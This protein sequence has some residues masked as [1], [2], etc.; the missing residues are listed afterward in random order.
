MNNE[1]TECFDSV[2][3]ATHSQMSVPRSNI[4]VIPVE[5][6]KQMKTR[7]LL[8]VTALMAA[9][10]AIAV[11]TPA[12]AGWT[13]DVDAAS[14][15]SRMK[16]EQLLQVRADG[17]FAITLEAINSTP[18]MSGLTDAPAAKA[19]YAVIVDG[20]VDRIVTWDGYSPNNYGKNFDK[21]VEAIS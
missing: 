15:V 11:P 3:P 20:V 14:T 9:T 18:Q 16:S 17:Y 10:F 2:N 6:E 8:T 13:T 21:I 5:K 12:I 19:K 7:S 4:L 1:T